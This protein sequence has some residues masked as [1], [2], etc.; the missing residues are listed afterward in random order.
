M[1]G[2]TISHY[3]IVEKLGGG[4]MGV[5]YKAK[6]TDL[7]RFVALKFLPDD[8]AQ[9]SQALERFRREAR[10]ASAL[11]HPN[12]C[13]IY[14]I[15]RHERQSFIAMEYLDGMT[16]RHCIAGRPLETEILLS[17]A[18]EIAD[19]LDAAHAAGIV[20]RDIK[21]A[22]IFV[23]KRGHAKILDF[24]LAKVTPVLSGVEDGGAD[25]QSTV[26]L[27]EHLTSPGAAVGTVAYMSPEQVR[28]RELDTRTDLFSFGVV[29]YEMATGALPFRGESSGVIFKAILDGTPASAVRLNPDLPADLER[30]INKALEKDRSLRYQSAA[31]MRTDLQRFRRDADSGGPRPTTAS[32]ASTQPANS[33]ASAS[34]SSRA[35]SERASGSSLAEIVHRHKGKLVAGVFM[36]LA[37]IAAAGY[38]VYFVSRQTPFEDFTITQVTNNGKSIAAAISPDG[39]YVFNVLDD[40]GK[41]S[42]WLLNIPTN[43]DTQVLAPADVSYDCLVFSPDGNHIYF[44]KAANNTGASFDLFRAPVLGGTPQLLVRNIDSGISF[45]PD[46]KRMTFMRVNDPEVGKFQ[47]LIAKADGTDATMLYGGATTELPGAVAWSPDGKQIALGYYHPSGALST[48]QLADVATGKVRPLARFNDRSIGDLVWAPNGRGLLTTFQVGAMPPPLR[49]QIGFVSQP[50]GE[51]HAVT[52]DTSSYQTLTLSADGKTLAAVQQRP[53]QTFYVMP[54]AGFTG[55]APAPAAAQSKDS[56]FF[57]WASNRE[58]YFDGDLV[59]VA[60]DGSHRT[61]LLRDP[62]YPLFRLTACQVG[63]YIAFV[64]HGHPDIG[65]TNIWRIDGAGTNPKQLSHGAVDVGPSCSPDGRW[66]YYRN[67]VDQQVMRVPIEGGEAEVVPGTVL[68]GIVLGVP[69][70]GL[71]HDGKFLAFVVTESGQDATPKIA[72]VDLTGAAEK[73]TRLLDADPRI[74]AEMRFVPGDQSVAYIIHENG[75]D[76]LWLQPLHGS[77]GHAITN[78]TSDVIQN[79]EYSPDGTTLGV[80]RSHTESD[81]VILHDTSDLPR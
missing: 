61:T 24:G 32:I 66:I 35:S 4:G 19:A 67:V 76:N 8:V 14:E 9:D 71:S 72:V 68:P 17:F 48:I 7:G 26:T 74:V 53:S 25:E 16:L 45:S 27:E 41:Q 78:F 79:F 40:K 81:V 33:R 3:H 56:R 59:R 77:R 55:P 43:S 6:D 50:G 39:K 34:T 73:R 5:V 54:A 22:N 37:L 57:A 29:L 60:L 38:G 1:I 44:R 51:F 70:I 21:P 30:V 47:I 31:E 10:A 28:A 46:G 75:A 2:Q 64:W 13:T 11:N 52:K 42:L 58:V 23:T 12:I 62:I 15:G 80:M 18:I 20:H 65:K 49:L 63:G 69:G 36:I